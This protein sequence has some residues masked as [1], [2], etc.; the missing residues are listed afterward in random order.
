MNHGQSY[1]LYI[2]IHVT[3]NSSRRF[4]KLYRDDETLWEI[5]PL[6]HMADKYQCTMIRSHLIKHINGNW[7]QNL[8]EW[9]DIET[10]DI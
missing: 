7:P 10:K 5:L 1:S 8:I 6:I 9:L 3:D 4:P 2:G